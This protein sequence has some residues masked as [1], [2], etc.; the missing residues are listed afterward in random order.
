MKKPLVSVLM[1]VYNSSKYLKEA[2][3]SVL[4]Q[5]YKNFELIIL[6][7]ASEDK[8][9]QIIKKFVSKN[10]KVRIYRNKKNRGVGTSRSKLVKLS[11]GNFLAIFDADD[12]MAENRLEEQVNFL[13]DSKDVVAVGSWTKVIDSRSEEIGFRK[14]PCEHKKIYQMMY[15][16]MGLQHPSIMINK[17]LLPKNF[18]WYPKR[19]RKV[20]DL[21]VLFKLLRYG[22]LANIPQFL[23]F[24]RV[25]DENLSLKKPKKTFKKAQIIR[26]KAVKLY[27]YKPNLKARLLNLL[28]RFVVSLLPEK[29]IFPLYSYF[30][31]QFF[32]VK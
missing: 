13:Q 29:Y 17:K 3:D 12:K 11:R 4:N 27:D 31:K 25:H 20:V 2:T 5:T 28:S 8:S 30:R 15:F 26:K 32:L 16:L 9:W 22:K 6:D 10:E 24:Y 21:P 18:K 7:D 19:E 1:P 23:T 14:L